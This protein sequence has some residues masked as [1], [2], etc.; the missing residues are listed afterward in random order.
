MTFLFRTSYLITGTNSGYLNHTERWLKFCTLAM[1]VT[2]G[3]QT[4]FPICVRK[5]E[6]CKINFILNFML[7]D[8][9]FH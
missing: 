3:L 4:V 5:L 1:Y 6:I 2:V 7:R 8:Q 9:M